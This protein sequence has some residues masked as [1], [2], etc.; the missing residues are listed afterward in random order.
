MK[1]L[2]WVIIIILV[3]LVAWAFVAADREDA[4]DTIRV[5]ALLS[6]TGDAGPWG[7]SARDGI[8]LALEEYNQAAEEKIEIV[9]E[10][11]AGQTEKAVSGYRKLVDTDKADAIMGPLLTAEVEAVLPLIEADEIPVVT[12]SAAIIERPNP[13][14][15]LMVWMDPKTQAGR[16]AV[17]AFSSGAGTASVIGSLDPW[18]TAVS[19]GFAEVFESLGGQIQ[20]K[21]LVQPESSDMR[22]T[23]TKVIADDPDAV[24][25]GTYYQFIPTTR[26]LNDLQY[27]GR[28][29]SIEVDSWLSEETKDFNNGLQF[30]APHLYSDEFVSKFEGAYGHKPG[31]PAGQA[32]DAMKILLELLATHDDKENIF[33]AMEAIQTYDGVAGTIEFTDD[34]RTL[35]PTAIFEL[36]DGE[37]IKVQ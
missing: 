12:P 6:L 21:E 16:M 30:I 28:M 20:Y 10:D 32:Y 35:F 19:E 14:N 24:F 22:T 13:R 27:P 3:V 29:Y 37:A 8:L 7:E 36:Q 17:Y 25:V 18:E 1:G 31:M 34:H 11:T 9:L 5:G 4:D 2:K 23:V 33:D 26:V 15:P